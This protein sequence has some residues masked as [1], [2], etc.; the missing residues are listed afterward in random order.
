VGWTASVA[1]A[2]GG[3]VVV[4]ADE[5]AVWLASSFGSWTGFSLSARER[6]PKP[7]VVF[8]TFCSLVS[9]TGAMSACLSSC[10][11][12]LAPSARAALSAGAMFASSSLVAIF[13]DSGVF[14]R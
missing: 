9:A 4:G 14:C 6:S 10:F 1:G 5:A 7:S 13:V 12:E 2:A 3:T 11:S 8:S